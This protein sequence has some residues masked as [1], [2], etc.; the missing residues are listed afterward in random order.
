MIE[1][2]KKAELLAINLQKV[3]NML[4]AACLVDPHS[5]F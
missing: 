1:A 2:L 5:F 3:T 4:L